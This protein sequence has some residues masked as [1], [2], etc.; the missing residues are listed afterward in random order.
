MSLLF[1]A[2]IT[3]IQEH[4]HKILPLI[5]AGHDDHSPKSRRALSRS[6]RRTRNAPRTWLPP[7]Q[8]CGA[9]TMPS[10]IS[11]RLRRTMPLATSSTI[12]SRRR[13]RWL[14]AR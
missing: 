14:P 9:E 3:V 1:P 7:Y 6:A 8:K 4:L 11:L 2:D 10:S 5:S 12:S 13:R